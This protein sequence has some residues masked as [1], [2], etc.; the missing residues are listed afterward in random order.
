MSIYFIFWAGKF[1]GP[2]TLEEA[3][4]RMAAVRSLD[5]EP[6]LLVVTAN[7]PE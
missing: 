2:Y 3:E 4:R 7:H 5:G 1:F 6:E